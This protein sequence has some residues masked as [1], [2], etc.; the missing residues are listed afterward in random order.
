MV[1]V[2]LWP[3]LVV[4][5]TVFCPRDRGLLPLSTN[6]RVVVYP[7]SPEHRHYLLEPVQEGDLSWRSFTRVAQVSIF[8][9]RTPRSASASRAAAAGPP[10]PP[11]R[12]GVR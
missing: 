6:V 9:R 10:H 12:P 1:P 8:R 7:S 4:E 2:S 5:G 11:S 3:S